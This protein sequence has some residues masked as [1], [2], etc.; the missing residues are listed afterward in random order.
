MP[1]SFTEIDRE[2]GRY[3]CETVRSNDQDVKLAAVGL[4]GTLLPVIDSPVSQINRGCKYFLASGCGD[5][6]QFLPAQNLL[7][8]RWLRFKKRLANRQQ[9]YEICPAVTVKFVVTDSQG[10][11]CWLSND[12]SEALAKS[13]ALTRQRDNGLKQN[14]LGNV[15]EHI[16]KHFNCLQ[17]W[18]KQHGMVAGVMGVNDPIL[19]PSKNYNKYAVCCYVEHCCQGEWSVG[20]ERLEQGLMPTLRTKTTI[21]N[22]EDTTMNKHS[23]PSQHPQAVS[24]SGC[25]PHSAGDSTRPLR[26]LSELSCLPSLHDPNHQAG[27]LVVSVMKTDRKRGKAA[28][29]GMQEQFRMKLKRASN[30]MRTPFEVLTLPMAQAAKAFFS[31][32]RIVEMAPFL[33]TLVFSAKNHSATPPL[34]VALGGTEYL[35]EQFIWTNRRLGRT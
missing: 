35:K 13:Y 18:F 30:D 1:D 10:R 25:V 26:R 33:Q 6:R 24:G 34:K 23:H 20:I 7:A 19:Q 15:A 29:F 14:A 22:G 16:G 11:R 5:E 9:T 21:A 3:R 12:Y 32:R 8:A 28:F 27:C 31:E 4:D 17:E 2:A